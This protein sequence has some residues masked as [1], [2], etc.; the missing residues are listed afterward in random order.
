MDSVVATEISRHRI[1][2]N[3]HESHQSPYRTYHS[4]ETALRRVSNDILHALDTKRSVIVILLD[5]VCRFWYHRSHRPSTHAW[6]PVWH[7]WNSAR[8]VHVILLNRSQKVLIHGQSSESRPLNLWVPQGSVLGP[9]LFTLYSA[10]TA[11]I[12]RVHGFGVHTC[13]DDTQLYIPLPLVRLSCLLLVCRR[14]CGI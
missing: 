7:W 1:E 8:V 13:A 3:L 5:I 10:A 6:G 11:D 9:L 2:N 12:V 4:T 14:W